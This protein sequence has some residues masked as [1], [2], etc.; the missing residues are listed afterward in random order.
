M[1]WQWSA[2]CGV[3]AAPYFRVFNPVRQGQKFDPAGKYVRKYVPEIAA[4]PDRYLHAPWE[5]PEKVLSQ[6]G[7]Q[8]GVDYPRPIVDLKVSR[9]EFLA[10]A[11]TVLKRTVSG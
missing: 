3:D 5:A 7:L 1:G 8:L 9:E 11:Q 4:L 10:H 6:A 2:G